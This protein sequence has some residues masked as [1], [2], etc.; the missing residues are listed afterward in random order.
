MKY[1]IKQ[2]AKIIGASVKGVADRD[3]DNITIDSRKLLLAETTLFIAIRGERNDG[4]DYVTYLYSK[5]VRAFLVDLYREEFD[6]LEEAVFL[7]VDDSLNAFHTFTAKHRSQFSYPV[8]AITGSNGKTIV[9]EWLYQMLMPSKK[10]VRSPKSYNSQVG[11]PLSLC[12]MDID[13]E[14]AIIEAGISQ[15]NEMEKLE[16]MIKPNIGVFTNLGLAH[17]ENFDSDIEKLREKLLLFKGVDS[18][19]ACI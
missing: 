17:N 11:V 9:K 14:I 2:I 12:L 19:I 4:H 10:V 18:L 1:S 15:K 3:V 5:G 13:D 7:L 8:I 6:V 16:K